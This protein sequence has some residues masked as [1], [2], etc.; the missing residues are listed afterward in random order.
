VTGVQT[1]ALPIYT[2]TGILN[3][4]LTVS[5]TGLYQLYLE[6]TDITAAAGPALDLESTS[7]VFIVTASDTTSSLT[8]SASRSMTMKAAVYGKGPMVFAGDGTLTVTGSYKHGVFSNDYIRVTGGTMNVA[9]STK[10]A[11]RSVNGFIFDDGILT[12][13]ATGTTTDDE[14]KGI[15]VEGS[16]TT[17]TGKGYVVINGG[18]IT[19]T[20]VSK[21]ITANWDIDEDAS[22]S[23]TADD[24]TP[25]VQINNGVITIKTTGTPYEYTSNGTT[26]SCSPEGIEGKSTV[27]INSGFITVNTADDC[28]NAG[29]SI[30]INGGCLYCYS[31]GNDAIDSNGT[32]TIAG[33]V[34]VAIGTSSP[35]GSIDC[36][37]NTFAIT[38]GTLVGIGGTISRPTSASCTQNV[39]ILGS[40]TSGTTM[41]L[42]NSSGATV[43]AFTIPK[44]YETMILSSP[45]IAS[46]TKYTVYT[47]G[48]ASSDATFHGLYLDNLGYSGGSAGSSLTISTVITKIGGTYF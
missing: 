38:G 32:M 25:Y 18:Y 16:E 41:A 35:E 17:G 40:L 8:D 30:V 7:K 1:C 4:T 43:F 9:V 21:A 22:T 14:S 37:N 48:T 36:D 42:K 12:I 19:I 27:T 29:N 6:G 24:P 5:S 46:S 26:V 23:S 11:I 34:V 20:S 47:G 39:V 45:S 31:T 33:G 2:L 13:N 28:V 44:A 15:K 3:G 10:D